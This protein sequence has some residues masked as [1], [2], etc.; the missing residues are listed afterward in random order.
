MWAVDQLFIDCNTVY[1]LFPLGHT[2]YNF[3]IKPCIFMKSVRLIKNC[4]N[5]M[6]SEVRISDQIELKKDAP[7]YHCLDICLRI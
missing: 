5:E 7:L 6:F 2:L 4:V 1:R 3:V